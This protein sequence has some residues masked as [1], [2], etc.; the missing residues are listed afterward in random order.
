M[1]PAPHSV[2]VL[3][4]AKSGK[5]SYAQAMAEG[6]GGRLIYVATAQAH[7]EEM[8]RRIARHQA[9]R[10]AAWSTLEEPLKLEA[11]LKKA[12]APDTVFLVDCL[13]LWLSNLV[14]GADLGDEAGE[15][16]GRGPG[17]ATAQ[18]TSQGDPGGQRG[19][20]GHR[21]RERVGP[22]L[23]RP[24][25]LPEPTPGP[26]LRRGFADHRGLPLALKAARCLCNDFG[27]AMSTLEGIIERIKPLDPSAARRPRPA[28]TT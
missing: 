25:R 1:S 3:G 14:L 9:D 23:A 21:A 27:E 7:D 22:P 2:L 13:T 26:L 20:P 17:P 6:W 12:D 10:G 24:G 16:A 19:G 28:W 18:A 11:A 15:R 8:T 4:G 5:S